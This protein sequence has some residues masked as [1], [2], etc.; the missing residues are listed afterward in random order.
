MHSRMWSMQIRSSFTTILPL[1]GYALG[2]I[3]E[4]P[5][6]QRHQRGVPKASQDLLPDCLETMRL[7]DRWLRWENRCH[8]PLLIHSELMTQKCEYGLLH[9]SRQFVQYRHVF[10]LTVLEH[11]CRSLKIFLIS[12]RGSLNLQSDHTK[13]LWDRTTGSQLKM[14]VGETPISIFQPVSDKIIY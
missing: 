10:P 3:R 1:A 13:M 12:N 7:L 6:A 8:Y 11:Q 9:A 4:S 5:P 14:G 2:A